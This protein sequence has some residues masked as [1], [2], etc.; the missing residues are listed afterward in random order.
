VSE[1]KIKPITHKERK[2]YIKRLR[3]INKIEDE[4]KKYDEIHRFRED[5]L[6]AHLPN[7]TELDEMTA[8]EVDELFRKVEGDMDF[9]MGLKHLMK[10]NTV[11]SS[12]SPPTQKQGSPQK[13]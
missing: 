6:K 1:L 7:G 9:Q 4:D 11:P 2:D 8:K 5:F 13:T 12:E 10:L 3:E